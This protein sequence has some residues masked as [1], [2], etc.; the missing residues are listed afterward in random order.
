LVVL[1]VGVV[2]GG[3]A[4]LYGWLPWWVDGPR[5]RVL[6]PKDQA[7]ILSSDRG[8]VLKM[9]AGAGALVALLY[10]ALKHR[11]ER[12]GQVTDRYTKA[13]AQLASE[14][15]SERIGAVYALERIMRDSPPD[16]LTVVEVLAAFVRERAPLGSGEAVRRIRNSRSARTERMR[17]RV[18]IQPPVRE[19]P[20]ADVQAAMTVL[21]RRP[22]RE[23]PFAIDLRRTM[24]AGLEL[25]PGARL[26]RAGLR[27]S[28]FTGAYL[29]GADLTEADLY[30]ATL[31]GATLLGA[32]LNGANLRRA[33]LAE[34]DLFE[35]TLSEANLRRATLTEANFSGATLT[36]TILFEATLTG[37]DLTRATL[38]GA[39]LTGAT[40]AGANLYG[41]TLTGVTLDG[42]T[43][44]G[45]NL[46]EATLTEANLFGVTLTGAMGL[47]ASQLSDAQLA[48]DSELDAELARDAWVLARIEACK[49]WTPYEPAPA[50]TPSPVRQPAQ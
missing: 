16:H 34:A 13:I 25:P 28:D 9:V 10:T 24:L 37:A 32:M 47:T 35:A 31:T 15:E 46:G 26:D 6:G 17:S 19:R 27:E 8:D 18:P 3:F 42:A 11:L 12:A 14:R 1:A 45:A 29:A 2:V 5:L 21:A 30:G 48:E 40:L 22:G 39:S 20:A 36:R 49:G 4:V 44:A 41:A 33:N 50:P 43:L 23:E 38:T 7:G